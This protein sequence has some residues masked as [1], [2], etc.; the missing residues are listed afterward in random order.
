M[1]L[2]SSKLA[3]QIS[4]LRV[5]AFLG[6][7]EEPLSD[8]L[9]RRVWAGSQSPG[10]EGMNPAWWLIPASMATLWDGEF[11]V[12]ET[13]ILIGENGKVSMDGS[14]HRSRD[15]PGQACQPRLSDALPDP[16]GDHSSFADQPVPFSEASC[17][18]GIRLS[19]TDP[20]KLASTLLAILSRTCQP[21]QKMPGLAWPWL[22]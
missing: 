5:R 21:V 3:M 12:P 2:N 14:F 10:K 17:D 11:L 19:S 8:H 18:P 7:P 20:G 4:P 22:S 6:T 16:P 9:G 15:A 13:P 1:I